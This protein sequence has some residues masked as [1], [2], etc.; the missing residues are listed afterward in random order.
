M[1]DPGS[2]QASNL[3]SGTGSIPH[4]LAD[5]CSRF[6][7]PREPGHAAFISHPDSLLGHP[8]SPYE[9]PMSA[10]SARYLARH[11]VKSCLPIF[12]NLDF[13]LRRNIPPG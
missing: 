12:E 3:K 9:C 6:P 11:Q 7:Q 10:I 8:A 1:L 5:E 2:G 4:S 13:I